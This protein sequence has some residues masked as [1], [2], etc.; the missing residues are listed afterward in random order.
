MKPQGLPHAQHKS[1][2]R[3]QAEVIGALL[4]AVAVIVIVIYLMNFVLPTVQEQRVQQT[5]RDVFER[6]RSLENLNTIFYKNTSKLCIEN[7]G[8]VVTTIVRIWY[9][10]P[11]G[12][13]AFKNTSLTLQSGQ[14]LCIPFTE[15]KPT[16]I[17]TARGNIFKVTMPQ[18][19][20]VAAAEKAAAAEAIIVTPLS[21]LFAEITDIE[22]LLQ[23]KAVYIPQQLLIEPTWENIKSGEVEGIM[24]A[25][26]NL[27]LYKEFKNASIVLTS[28]AYYL[29]ETDD[30]AVRVSNL[31]VGLTPSGKVINCAREGEERKYNLL[32]TGIGG[33]G[34]T[35]REKKLSTPVLIIK[36][37]NGNYMIPI[38]YSLE[39]RRFERTPY[40]I[41]I[42]GLK[43]NE[44]FFDYDGYTS[45]SYYNESS[46]CIRGLGYWWLYGQSRARLWLYLNGTADKVEIYVEG[47]VPVTNYRPYIHIMDVDRNGVGEVFFTTEDY[48]SE[49]PCDLDDA[50]YEYEFFKIEIIE[51]LRDMS[52]EVNRTACS[53][54]LQLKNVY[55]EGVRCPAMF[56]FVDERYRVNGNKYAMVTLA[57]KIYYHDAEGGDVDCVDNPR[58]FMIGFFLVDPGPDGKPG[59]YNDTIVSANMLMYQQLDDWEDTWP[60]NKNFITLMVPL[61][62]P[63]EDKEFYV[64]VGFM[65]P[66]GATYSGLDDVE[67]TAAIELIGLTFYLRGG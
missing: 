34:D 40:R 17:V 39:E 33:L 14:E 24:R 53:F 51:D 16:Y 49:S 31:F 58:A 29:G 3:G 5:L 54:A 43:I 65:D 38:G 21:T 13:L 37:A 15:G 55:G 50:I 30:K 42:T 11:A 28:L 66:Y 56:Y 59:D 60:P 41:K 46:L 36:D 20:V 1:R 64:A 48:N 6:E 63:E 19:I 57:V 23:S 35:E 12:A 2:L 61:L 27:Y 32:V 45:L 44:I 4:A 52:T 22:D 10:T 67:F 7:R 9:Q 18:E 25:D 47:N 26:R 8:G 62:V